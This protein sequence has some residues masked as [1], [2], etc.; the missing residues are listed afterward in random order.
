MADA[1]ELASEPQRPLP[2]KID[3]E[4]PVLWA[5][6]FVACWLMSLALGCFMVYELHLLNQ[7]LARFV[8]P[9]AITEL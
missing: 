6:L 9:I 4:P 2:A 8:E 3:L 7:H 1:V 5:T